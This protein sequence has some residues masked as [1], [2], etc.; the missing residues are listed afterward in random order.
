M[1]PLGFALENFDAVGKW[2]TTD[3]GGT[4]DPSS[5]LANGEVVAGPNNLRQVLVRHSAEFAEAT[6]ARLLTYALGR[7]LDA[8]DQ[9]TVRKIV[10]EAE[11][12]RYKFSDLIKGI[13]SSAPFQMRQTSEGS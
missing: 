5:Q 1:D 7:Q 8:Q 4:I 2:R 10:R 6:V 3:E 13:V 9:P 12:G 11:P